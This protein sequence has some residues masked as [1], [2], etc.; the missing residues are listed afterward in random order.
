M[1]TFLCRRVK[2][3]KCGLRRF[4]CPLFICLRKGRKIVVSVLLLINALAMSSFHRDLDPHFFKSLEPT[5]RGSPLL[6]TKYA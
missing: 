5:S 6:F 4:E 2:F 3:Q 1:E